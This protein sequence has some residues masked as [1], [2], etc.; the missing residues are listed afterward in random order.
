MDYYGALLWGTNGV[1]HYQRCARRRM[2][3]INISSGL[4]PSEKYVDENFHVGYRFGKGSENDLVD[5]L[6]TE[7]EKNENC[8]RDPLT[9]VNRYTKRNS[10]SYS[11]EL[12]FICILIP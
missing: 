6:R 7:L 3:Q 2:R 9:C 8:E 1:I 11:N 12:R 5:L 10:G 4:N